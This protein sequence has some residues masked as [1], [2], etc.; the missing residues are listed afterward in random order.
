VNHG[1]LKQLCLELRKPTAPPK[2][3]P[4][5]GE[6]KTGPEIAAYASAL[7]QLQEARHT[8]DY[9]PTARFVTSDV[10]TYIGIAR[11]GV[12]RFFQATTEQRAQF[13]TLLLSPPR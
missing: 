6:T 3:R 2:W 12:S 13:L 10:L 9:D 7:V 11:S 5:I 1:D 4:Y 8:A